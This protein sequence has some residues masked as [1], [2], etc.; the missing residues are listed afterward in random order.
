MRKKFTVAEVLWERDIW[1]YYYDGMEAI[2]E[3]RFSD[4]EP[5][6]LEI[7]KLNPEFP[8]SYEGLAVM[9]MEK[10]RKTAI[11]RKRKY[12]TAYSLS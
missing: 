4:A 6:F 8:G 10:G 3:K 1:R 2:Q 9:A 11:R 12:C 5:C 7:I